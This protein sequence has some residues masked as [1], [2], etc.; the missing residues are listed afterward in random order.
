MLSY[1][2]LKTE[3]VMCDG[4]RPD[5]HIPCNATV[6]RCTACGNEGC[7]QMRPD[8]CTKQAF[9]TVFKCLK[10]GVA[11]KQEALGPRPSDLRSPALP[12]T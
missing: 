4:V 10:C 6:Y 8:R 9:D 12:H 2:K 1:T 7:R 3:E 5:H 11:G